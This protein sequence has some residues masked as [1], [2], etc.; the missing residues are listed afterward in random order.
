MKNVDAARKKKHTPQH[1]ACQHGKHRREQKDK[2]PGT[3]FVIRNVLVSGGH[4]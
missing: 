1:K 4:D 3:A 2:Q